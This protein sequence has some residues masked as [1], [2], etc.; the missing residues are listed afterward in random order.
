MQCKSFLRI[1]TR[2]LNNWNKGRE[3][4]RFGSLNYL[5]NCRVSRSGRPASS[6]FP[7][8][9]NKA[10]AGTFPGGLFALTTV[11]PE[12]CC[13]LTLASPHLLPS[14]CSHKAG[15]GPYS[16]AEP[17]GFPLPGRTHAWSPKAAPSGLYNPRWNSCSMRSPFSQSCS[18]KGMASLRRAQVLTRAP[19]NETCTLLLFNVF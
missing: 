2:T 12:P 11:W 5:E 19:H 16:P 13:P 9:Q 15:A 18:G 6:H 4:E 10:T 3:R 8:A 7:R 14:A 1:P 17:G